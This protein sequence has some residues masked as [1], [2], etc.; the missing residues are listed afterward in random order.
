M[1]FGNL[2]EEQ[3]SEHYEPILRDANFETPLDWYEKAGDGEIEDIDNPK[4]TVLGEEDCLD[5]LFRITTYKSQPFVFLAHNPEIHLKEF[6]DENP[7]E[8]KREHQ[9]LAEIAGVDSDEYG[10]VIEPNWAEYLENKACNNSNSGK[11]WSE[12][13]GFFL[14]TLDKY[15]S[16][17]D[18]PKVP[19]EFFQPDGPGSVGPFFN[20]FYYTN[21]FKFPTHTGE[22]A[23]VLGTDVDEK[24]YHE[25]LRDELQATS[26]DVVFLFGRHAYNALKSELSII[27]IDYEKPLN[28]KPDNIGEA[29]GYLFEWEAA[30]VHAI[31]FIHFSTG[32]YK[33]ELKDQRT[34]RSMKYLSN[35]GV[36]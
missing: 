1:A 7:D 24:F 20:S 16:E 34:K 6:S 19:R 36:V 22:G 27:D 28:K 18:L 21:A 5:T 23:S 11:E 17:I 8:H 26:A 14:Q 4:D 29:H 2:L 35:I 12:R 33:G 13:L 30:D 3:W 32:T 25:L 10:D 31:A 9:K 15:S